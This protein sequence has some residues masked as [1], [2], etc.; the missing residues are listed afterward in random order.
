MDRSI[1]YPID[2][3]IKLD[4][5]GLRNS[6]DNPSGSVRFDLIQY[7]LS[8]NFLIEVHFISVIVACPRD[9]NCL[10]DLDTYDRF[11]SSRRD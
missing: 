9:T 11:Y 7:S 5:N 8:R 6:G 4:Q 10:S 2:P 1:E 3:R